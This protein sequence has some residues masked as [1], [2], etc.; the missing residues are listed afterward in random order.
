MSMPGSR[1]PKAPL[2]QTIRRLFRVMRPQAFALAVIVVLAVIGVGFS[3][4][5][6]KVLGSATDVIFDGFVSATDGIDF[7]ALTRLLMLALGLYLVAS[8]FQYNRSNGGG[9]SPLR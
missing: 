8:L 2:S 6:P 4:L 3:V 5:G 9:A 7:A 1:K